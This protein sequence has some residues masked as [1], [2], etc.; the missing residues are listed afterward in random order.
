MKEL[1]EQLN[2]QLNQLTKQN[3]ILGGGGRGKKAEFLY[4]NC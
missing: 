2:E 3:Q 1:F 4:R